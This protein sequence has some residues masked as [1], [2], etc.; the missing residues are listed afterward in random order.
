MDWLVVIM[1]FVGGEVF[2][3]E[4]V[5]TVTGRASCDAY[6]SAFIAGMVEEEGAAPGVRVEHRC[7]PKDQGG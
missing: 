6:G 5:A 4:T 7:I 3:T 1:I 2:A